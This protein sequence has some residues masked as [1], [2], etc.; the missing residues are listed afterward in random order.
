M[1]QVLHK[2]ATLIILSTFLSSCFR[3]TP[4]LS[5]KEKWEEARKHLDNR[6]QYCN[7]LSNGYKA[8]SAGTEATY[9]PEFL[10]EYGTC[11]KKMDLEKA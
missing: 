1:P 9:L 11:L 3:Y 5:A 10:Y 2:L 8:K 4:D 6:D 7:S